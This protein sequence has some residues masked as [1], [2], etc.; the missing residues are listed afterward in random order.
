[1]KLLQGS[2]IWMESGQGNKMLYL[3]ANVV[4][5][6]EVVIQERNPDM[7]GPRGSTALHVSRTLVLL[8]LTE[9]IGGKMRGN[10]GEVMECI[11]A[12]TID[13][14]HVRL[15]Q[16]CL[17]LCEPMHCSPPGFFLC[18]WDSPG[19]NT[20]I[21]CH[22]LLQGISQPRDWTHVSCISCIGRHIFYQFATQE[23][24]S[25]V[26]VKAFQLRPRGLWRLRGGREKWSWRW[27]LFW[28]K[29]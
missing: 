1:M 12:H 3:L 22:F 21:S 6:R 8:E 24:Q 14:G 5:A 7:W 23:A 11:C 25:M 27:I 4:E 2:D 20:G 15:A 29:T 13:Y 28:I 16:A 18:P 26:Y 19:K 9:G 17:I 10:G